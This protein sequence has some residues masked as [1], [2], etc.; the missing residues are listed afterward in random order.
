[1]IVD[2]YVVVVVVVVVAVGAHVFCLLFI[3]E[4]CVERERQGASIKIGQ[5]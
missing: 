2:V 5:R 1:M 4:C 3:V